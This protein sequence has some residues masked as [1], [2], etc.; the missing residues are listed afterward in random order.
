MPAMPPPEPA[1]PTAAF[2]ARWRELVARALAAED[3]ALAELSALPGGNRW[4]SAHDRA[5]AARDTLR[6]LLA[7]RDSM[8]ERTK[9]Q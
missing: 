9:T 4:H 3:A 5:D 2:V 1:Q 6:R 7:V 8:T